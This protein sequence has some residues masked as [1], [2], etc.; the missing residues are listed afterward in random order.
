MPAYSNPSPGDKGPRA[1]RQAALD[2]KAG[3]V[4]RRTPSPSYFVLQDPAPET[5]IAIKR[6]AERL[7]LPL[8]ER[9]RF[10][11]VRA[12]AEEWARLWFEVEVDALVD[13]DLGQR[14]PARAALIR[15]LRH[16]RYGGRP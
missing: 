14:D 3:V 12:S 2:A 7:R 8:V 11:G 9:A 4:V 15:L 1:A 5:A 10:M 6:A 13:A 16:R